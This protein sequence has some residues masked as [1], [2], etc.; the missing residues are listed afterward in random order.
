MGQSP[1][2]MERNFLRPFGGLYP[3]PRRNSSSRSSSSRPPTM[4]FSS[5]S[6]G[7]RLLTLTTL[8]CDWRF[9][10]TSKPAPGAGLGALLG[11]RLRPSFALRKAVNHSFSLDLR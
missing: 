1:S 6:E 10:L 5:S 2:R 7:A 4:S 9:F 8:A 11:L 3:V